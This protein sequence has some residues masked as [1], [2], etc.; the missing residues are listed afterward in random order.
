MNLFLARW[1]EVVHRSYRDK[2]NSYIPPE[3]T[4]KGVLRILGFSVQKV[5]SLFIPGA[6]A[7]GLVLV[8]AKELRGFWAIVIAHLRRNLQGGCG[9]INAGNAVGGTR[10]DLWQSV[11]QRHG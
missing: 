1:L 11:A 4:S 7:Q 2:S 9:P 6:V 5:L 10:L 3:H 8:F